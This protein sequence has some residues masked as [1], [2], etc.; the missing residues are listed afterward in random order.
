MIITV[1]KIGGS[2]VLTFEGGVTVMLET[3][4]ALQLGTVLL[5]VSALGADSLD[6]EKLEE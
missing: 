1:E 6:I 4:D 3:I 2:V 5:Q